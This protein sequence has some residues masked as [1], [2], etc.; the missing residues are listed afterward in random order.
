[1][2]IISKFAN[3]AFNS[4]ASKIASDPFRVGAAAATV[5]M[6]SATSKDAVN[7]YYYVTQSLKNEKIP[8]E[9]RKFVA[10]LDLSNGILNI[11]TQ[12]AMGAPLLKRIDG[13]FDTK[14]AP[15]YFDNNKVIQS[16]KSKVDDD[17]FETC[18]K[19]QK[20]A[21]K[22]GLGI[23]ATLVVTQII[24]KRI[25]VP[26]L[27]TPMAS[28][29]KKKMEEKSAAKAQPAAEN[30]LPANSKTIDAAKTPACFKPFK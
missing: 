14:I 26:L 13:F 25:I 21:A 24:A 29:I 30:N 23:V 4:K 10:A 16:L 2:S 1:M 7:C 20:S 27:A 3:Y 6:V 9:K 12:I 15:K 28:V 5:A 17:I 22:A 18:L 19:S 8:E 11:I